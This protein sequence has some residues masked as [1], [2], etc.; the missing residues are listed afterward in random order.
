M[1]SYS[2]PV[3][4]RSR[5]KRA[6]L[7][8]ARCESTAA[9]AGRPWC[10]RCTGPAGSSAETSGRL[11]RYAP[12]LLQGAEPKVGRRAAGRLEASFCATLQ[13]RPP[14]M[15][16]PRQAATAHQPC[17]LVRPHSASASE[18]F[19]E[20]RAPRLP[21][22][23]RIESHHPRHRVGAPHCHLLTG[24]DTL[25]HPVRRP[26]CPLRLSPLVRRSRSA[27]SENLDRWPVG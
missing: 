22:R 7:T 12:P 6:V 27:P 18:V 9:L 5:P 26:C 21:M 23:G 11:V 24:G 8:H 10:R 1:T 19:G 3:R 4:C 14:A 20:V 2:A 16:H 25:Q 15:V 17:R 13:Q